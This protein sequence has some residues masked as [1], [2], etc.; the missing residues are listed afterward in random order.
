M[1]YKDKMIFDTY[2]E[3]HLSKTIFLDR[4]KD[5]LNSHKYSKYVG[6]GVGYIKHNIFMFYPNYHEL[7]RI[8]MLMIMYGIN[9]DEL[10]L[11]NIVFY[12]YRE[13]VRYFDSKKPI[14]IED[15]IKPLRKEILTID[16]PKVISNLPVPIKKDRSFKGL[17][18]GIISLVSIGLTIWLKR[19]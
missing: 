16:K 7:N 2:I 5:L 13:I 19:K 8:K 3:Y 18:I 1:N 14:T 4:F 17:F 15:K 12:N 6:S 11:K 9:I 10:Y